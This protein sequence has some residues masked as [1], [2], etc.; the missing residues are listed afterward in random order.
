MSG[1]YPRYGFRPDYLSNPS[2]LSYDRTDPPPS[3]SFPQS[4]PP[5]GSGFGR[6]TSELAG[7]WQY[8]NINGPFPPNMVRAGIDTDGEVIYVGRAFHEGDLVPAKVIP[9][10]NLSFIC[11]GGEEILKE[12]FEVLRYGA[13]VWEF[14]S[15]GAVPETALKI[16]ATTDGEPLYMGRAIHNGSQTPGKVHPSH[17]CCYIPFDG[18]ELS[19]PDYEV[20]CVR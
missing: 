3:S 12:D 10:K 18:A 5:T 8:C 11:H 1:G 2:D 7:C 6:V 13:F 19:M 4:A 15:G 17:G 14:S 9:T 16:G 20:L